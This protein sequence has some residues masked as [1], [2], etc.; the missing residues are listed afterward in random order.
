MGILSSLFGCKPENKQDNNKTASKEVIP[1]HEENWDFYFSNVDDVLGSINLD[2]GLKEIAPIKSKNNVAW[3]SVLM[4]KPKENGLSSNEESSKLFEIEDS[5]VNTI[6]NSIFVGRLTSANARDFYF[7]IKDTIN[8]EIEVKKAM[9]NFSSYQFQLG[10]KPDPE[11]DGY[12]NFLYPLPQQMQCIQNRQ[13]IEN[14]EKNGDSLTKER[15]VTHWSYFPTNKD[16]TN[17]KDSVST[18]GFKIIESKKDNSQELTHCLIYSKSAN[19]NYQNIDDIIIPI[20]KLS[21]ECNGDY[22]GWETSV[23]K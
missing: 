3:V 21:K 13:V 14:L 7:Y 20:W 16:L 19:I 15:E 4:Q 18:K 2:L 8:F 10:T 5:I 11:W 22:D 23:E 9:A 12:L 6:S 17:F 1:N